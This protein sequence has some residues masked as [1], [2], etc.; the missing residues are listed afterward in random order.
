M[1]Q[2]VA[3]HDIDRAAR[4]LEGK[5]M[6]LHFR[7]AIAPV[8]SWL[9]SLSI[10][11][12]D[13]R[14]S[15]W[16]MYASALSMTN[17]LSGVEE[18]LEAAETALEGAELDETT[19]NLIG[20]IAAIR[21]LLAA[22]QYQVDTV[23][24]QSHRALEYLRPDNLPVRTATVWKLGWAYLMQ[25][26]RAAASQ[27]LSEAVALSKASGN[28]II[29][30]SALVSLGVVQETELQLALAAQTYQQALQQ[31]GDLPQPGAGEAHLGLARISYEWN[32]FE[33]AE[34][35]G[36]M[37]LQLARQVE[38]TDRYLVGEVFLAR[39]ELARGDPDGAAARL[40]TAA[41]S[42]R[43]HHFTARLP[44]IA[45]AQVVTWLRQGQL[46]AAAQLAAS[47]E[48]PLSRARVQLAHDDPAAALAVLVPW[49]E[50][51][52]ARGWPDAQ[53]QELLQEG[54]A[55]WLAGQRE[56]AVDAVVAAVALAEP[57]GCVRSFVDAGALMAEL[58]TEV[59][60]RGVLPE[61]VEQLRAACA[62][63]QEQ[64]ERRHAGGALSSHIPALVEPLSRREEEVLRLIAQGLSNQEI[65][66]RL[67]VALDTVKG[68]NQKIF[69]KLQVQRR[70]E[71][72]A[73]ARELGLL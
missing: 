45:A 67:V 10:A 12:L 59:A 19:R 36:Q 1:R 69:S 38:S 51:V 11:V 68:H 62:A 18:K 3:A 46:A 48:D 32:D 33:A 20:H 37:S 30:L 6:P 54:L 21:A 2:A 61:Y 15:L 34:R 73:R 52:E 39:L 50:E 7:G 64:E 42:A 58:L 22:T 27:A 72:V 44:E 9:E 4:L 63:E 35:H 13:A 56:Q 25:G 65:A 57:A 43:Q 24:A 23:I 41:Q 53:L 49:R 28:T 26:D 40:A 17:N 47:Y 70:T 8:L 14:P 66:E 31:T 5:G 55:R 71:A 29:Y 60:A 16:V